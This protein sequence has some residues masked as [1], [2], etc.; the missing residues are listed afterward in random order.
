MGAAAALKAIGDVE[1]VYD[2][3]H[4][5]EELLKVL[6]V[7]YLTMLRAIH[8]MVLLFLASTA[9]FKPES[10]R[11]DDQAT[12]RVLQEAADRVVRID[13]TTRAEIRQQ[14]QV[15]QERGYSAWQIAHGVP[16]DDYPGIDGLFKERWKGRAGMVA[17]TELQHAQRT[18]ALNRYAA[19]GLVDRV[20]II[21]GDQWDQTCRNRDGKVVPIEQAP[22]LAHPNCTL[23]LVPVLREGVA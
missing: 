10:F 2:S 8:Q 18:S 7:V 16:K 19:S 15:G 22:D 5:Q 14:L 4:E 13:E 3:A 20:R 12:R 1:D 17:R 23:V 21:D 6:E 11:L 9:T